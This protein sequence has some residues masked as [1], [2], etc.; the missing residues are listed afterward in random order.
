VESLLLNDEVGPLG[1]VRLVVAPPQWLETDV[2]LVTWSVSIPAVVP[3]D[4]P[5]ADPPPV[6][7]ALDPV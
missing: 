1:L 3:V 5:V 4:E 7:E 2:A 6:A